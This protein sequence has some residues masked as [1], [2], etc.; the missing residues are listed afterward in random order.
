MREPGL[1]RVTKD[2]GFEI[3]QVIAVRLDK[4]LRR[5]VIF[6]MRSSALH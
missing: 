2:S 3:E 4:E 5:P 6:G 1:G